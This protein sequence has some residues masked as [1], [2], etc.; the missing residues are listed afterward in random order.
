MGPMILGHSPKAVKQA[1]SEQRERGLLLAAQGGIETGGARR[2]CARVPCAE[3][4]RF[5]SW[6][7]E[8]VQAA[9][10]LA[11][12]ATGRT[13]IVKFEGHYHGWL[14]NILWSVAPSADAAGPREA[15][16]AVAASKG[17]DQE[18]GRNTVV[19]PWNDLAVI[20]K[21]LAQGDVALGITEPGSG[22][23][24][25]ILPLQGSL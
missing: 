21:R 14:D 12:A 1:V 13:I 2:A 24:G 16:N 9:I 17:Q 7:S 4:L 10:R 15:P 8:A 3:R 25:G 22:N 23:S 6:G 20:E 19:L 5:T 18:A 11:R